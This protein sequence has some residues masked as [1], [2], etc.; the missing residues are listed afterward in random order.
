ML[1]KLSDELRNAREKS[2]ITLQQLAARTRIDIKFLE[3]IDNG[4]FSFLPEIY[5]KAFLKQYARNIGLDEDETIKKYD[6][7]IGSVP[8]EKESESSA[9]DNKIK[10]TAPQT[11]TRHEKQSV[12]TYDD[13]STINNKT[14]SDADQK[15]KLMMFAA[16]VGV[17]ALTLIIY[18]AFFQ[19]GPEII[20]EEKPYEEIVEDTP[21]RF[22]DSTDSQAIIPTSPV[23]IDSLSL[24]FTNVDSADTSW[25][26]VISDNDYQQDFLL[27]P[28]RSKTVKAAS[29]FKF[30]LGNSGVVKIELDDKA[31]SFEGR[32]GSVRYFKVDNS[33]IQ[34]LNSP[35]AINK[36]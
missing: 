9:V 12:R 34:R 26:L 6:S 22:T 17:I 10:T 14:S 28:Q 18:F 33:G 8:K 31:I 36:N 3:A 24:K 32:R 1:E 7:A 4:N 11:S 13:V 27:Y 15:A 35:P 2:G 29:A 20:V 23:L 21:S 30:T 19:K 5:V 25:I 16:S